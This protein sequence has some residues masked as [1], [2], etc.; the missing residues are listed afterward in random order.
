M[1][2]RFPWGIVL[3][4][5]ALMTS[6]GLAVLE[7]QRGDVPVNINDVFVDI[8]YAAP[9]I[10]VGPDERVEVS[11]PVTNP[12][13][14]EVAL[15]VT[16][17]SCSCI[18]ARVEPPVLA[19]GATGHVVIGAHVTNPESRNHRF[20]VVLATDD[21]VPMTFSV[22]A[23]LQVHRTLEFFPNKRRVE[24]VASD[25][26]IIPCTIV[27]RGEG[28][29]VQIEL[30]GAR[31]ISGPTLVEVVQEEGF[32]LRTYHCTIAVEPA[33]EEC[34][35]VAHV[36]AKYGKSSLRHDIRWERSVGVKTSPARLFFKPLG[37]GATFE[38]QVYGQ[39]EFSI[40]EIYT[41]SSL[42]GLSIDY[43]DVSQKRHNVRLTF[44]IPVESQTVKLAITTDLTGS[45]K[46]EVPVFVLHD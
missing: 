32:L 21:V 35:G 13:S 4:V 12:F 46:F 27:T 8:E 37:S 20:T 25:S 31:E 16:S 39:D 1:R 9:P 42:P 41:E 26:Q 28:D 29:D 6:G 38:F 43:P 34:R 22:V 45:S 3:S 17:R 15:A 5:A 30:D 23:N 44:P 36:T 10:L 33:A 14:R 40:T 18:A 7:L 2:S 24:V 11:V 19:A